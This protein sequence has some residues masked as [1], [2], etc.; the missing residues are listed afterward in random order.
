LMKPS[1]VLKRIEDASCCTGCGLCASLAPNAIT[2][3]MKATGFL[4]PVQTAAVSATT[5]AQIQEHCP[6]ISI[7]AE[8]D[9]A[10]NHVIWGPIVASRT[11]F[12][13][14]ERLRKHASS[15]GVISALASYLIETKAVEYVLQVT[16]SDTSPLDNQTSRSFD[17]VS[18]FNSAGSRYA[19]SSP[20]MDLHKHL[21][22]PGVFGVVGKPCDIAALRSLA[23]TDDRIDK[24]IP[25]MISFFCAGI[26]SRNA[27]VKIVNT[28]GFQ[29][30][31]LNNFRYRGDG[32]PGFATA[33]TT[34]G[35]EARMSYNDSWGN[36]LSKQVQFRCKICPDGS[37]GQ[38]DIVC[39][40]AW[41]SDE[42][43]YPLFAETDGRSLVISR[44]K[45]GEEVLQKA[46]TH[47]VVVCNDLATDEIAK[48]QPF[49]A[50]R[51]RQVIS[52][53]AAMRIAGF[54]PPR[55]R[56]MQL[57]R[58]ALQAG[59]TEN[60]RGFWGTLRRLPKKPDLRP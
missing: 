47:G 36:I 53:L 50:K 38:A 23:R 2:M 21:A 10:H 3:E 42:R 46:M 1:P 16:A 28:L 9:V 22:N 40:D 41:E 8:T 24:K 51:K 43:G 6:G 20:L 7:A 45:R 18:V 44:T 5:D 37:G 59:V 39:G 29:E 30:S 35:R 48:M 33:Q 12:A 54:K 60:I 14:D 32:W 19:P 25:L 11:G 57:A 31:E 34:D 26:P 15:G 27:S 56:G 4:R 17:A 13:T 52:R 55:Y 49:Q 58:A